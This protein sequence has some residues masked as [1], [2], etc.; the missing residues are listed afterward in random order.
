ML[1]FS[2]WHCLFIGLN[3]LADAMGLGKTV[4][5]ISLILANPDKVGYEVK[6]D[7]NEIALNPCMK[8]VIKSNQDLN[9]NERKLELRKSTNDLHKGGGTLIV[10]PTTLLRQWKLLYLLP[11]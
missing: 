11:L 2:F 1:S 3:I 5:T 8:S 9:E 7:K 4:M 6:G 10:C